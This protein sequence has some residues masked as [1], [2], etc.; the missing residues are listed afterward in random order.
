MKTRT[1][2]WYF[3]FRGKINVASQDNQRIDTF[4]KE[5]RNEIQ[6]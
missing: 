1:Q 4:P 3:W 5:T 6:P 2:N